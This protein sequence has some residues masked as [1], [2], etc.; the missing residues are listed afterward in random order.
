MSLARVSSI[1]S[2]KY[3]FVL[4]AVLSVPTFAVDDVTLNKADQAIN[5]A[6]TFLRSTQNA[7]GSWS[8]DAGPAVTSLITAGMLRHPDIDRNDPTVAKALAYILKQQKDDGGFYDSFLANYNTSISLSAL[9]RLGDDPEIAKRIKKAHAFL[10]GIQWTE[11]KTDPTGKIIDKSH[12]YYGGAG[13][14]KHG[15]PDMSNTQIM[16]EGL[17][18]SGLDCNDP[19]FIRAQAFITRC[20][21]VK[22]NKAFGDKIKPDG[23]FIYSTSV[24]KNLIGVPQSQADPE[25][26]DAAKAGNFRVVSS[27]RTYGSMTYAGFKS[28]LYA[29]LDNN[30][31]RV[32]AAFGWIRK[33]YTVDENPGMGMQ[34]YFYYLHT[35]TRA[36]RAWGKPTIQ[37]TDGKQHDWAAEVIAKLV[38]LQQSNGSWTN[39]ADRWM[40]ADPNL[41][42]AYALTAL[43]VAAHGD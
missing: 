43:H 27:L 7:D 1:A 26:S 42:T 17:L 29:K 5:K 4:I 39:P 22:Q 6:I 18:D 34:G 16:L 19:A 11:G 25:K 33:N 40:E 8:P 9:G 30:D 10:R 20:Q 37:T 21:G 2:R 15:R 38:S 36:L 31:P 23:G 13:Y 35:F 12:P 28:Y 3:V 24:N 32:V 41:V 14:G